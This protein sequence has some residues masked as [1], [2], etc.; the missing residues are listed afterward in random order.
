MAWHPFSQMNLSSFN[1][2][3][4]NFVINIVP[5]FISEN[6]ISASDRKHQADS[7]TLSFPEF[8]FSTQI[9]VLVCK[10][11]CVDKPLRPCSFFV[12]HWFLITL[13]IKAQITV[14]MFKS[15]PWCFIYS[16]GME[17]ASS[18]QCLTQTPPFLSSIWGEKKSKKKIN[19]IKAY[20]T[21]SHSFV[22][23]F[24]NSDFS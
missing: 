11:K 24:R 6:Y 14:H 4:Q 22:L 9:S 1:F 13:T 15:F 20:G 7:Y 18:E 19:K 10:L 17:T 23:K 21:E 16:K 2:K 5:I 12:V 3:L 8:G